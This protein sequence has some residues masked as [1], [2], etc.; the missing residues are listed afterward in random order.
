M[1]RLRIPLDRAILLVSNVTL[2][3]VTDRM[4]C[5]ERPAAQMHLAGSLH[6]K[7]YSKSDRCS[8]GKVDMLLLSDTCKVYSGPPALAKSRP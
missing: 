8:Y 5:V 1:R 4:L 6:R 7:E 2:R 3:Q